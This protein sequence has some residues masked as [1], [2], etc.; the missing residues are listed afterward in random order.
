MS[1]LKIIIP[2]FTLIVFSSCGETN[3]PKCNGVGHF[4]ENYDTIETYIDTIKFEVPIDRI[5]KTN[6]RSC[7]GIGRKD[8][9]FVGRATTILGFSTT[10][11][12]ING[13]LE[14][15]HNNNPYGGS[16]SGKK[17]Q[18]CN[19]LGDYKCGTCNGIGYKS[20]KKTEYE[21]QT[22]YETKI[23]S[24]TKEKE[25]VDEYCNGTGVV[26]KFSEMFK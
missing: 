1:K 13:T 18:E 24:V 25:I 4:V 16:H 10:Y 9:Q 8:C 11:D 2:L 19:G 26:G 12:C 5:V 6:C 15:S 7:N 23:K 3:C 21:T 22:K 14:V 20:I 17:C